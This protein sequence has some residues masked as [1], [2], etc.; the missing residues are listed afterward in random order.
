MGKLSLSVCKMFTFIF[1][2]TSSKGREEANMNTLPIS[3]RLP[4]TKKNR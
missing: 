1:D 4:E 2:F 3:M